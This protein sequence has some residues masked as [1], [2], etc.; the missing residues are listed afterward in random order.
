MFKFTKKIT[1]KY[2][3]F[4][5]QL[6]TY[7]YFHESKK[8]WNLN[9]LFNFCALRFLITSVNSNLEKREN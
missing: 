5:E 4:Y 1:N 6:K 8:I 9:F 7:E 2:Q 3:R